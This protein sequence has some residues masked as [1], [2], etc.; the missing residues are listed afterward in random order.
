M[1]PSQSFQQGPHP[2]QSVVAVQPTVFVTAAPLPNPVPDYM[3]YSIF[4]MLCCCWPLGIAAL[5]Y[6]CF[7]RDANHLGQRHL[8]EKN[9]KRARILN[10]VGLGIGIC[11]ITVII[12]SQIVNSK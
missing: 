6:S 12:I 8:A 2:A 9:S 7:T 11:L 3:G 10:H 5:V 4:I 1:D